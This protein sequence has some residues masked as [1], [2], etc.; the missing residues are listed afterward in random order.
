MVQGWPG[1]WAVYT[2]YMELPLSGSLHAGISFLPGAVAAPN[3]FPHSSGQKD[4]GVVYASLSLA[5][6]RL[7]RT[8]RAKA[9][10]SL[11]VSVIP[12]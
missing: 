1:D 10:V 2:R 7:W 12:S 11:P 3:S 5:W 9:T 4:L 8:L 6:Y